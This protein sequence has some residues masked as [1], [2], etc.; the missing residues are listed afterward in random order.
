MCTKLPTIVSKTNPQMNV[1]EKW[2]LAYMKHITLD[3]NCWKLKE[4]AWNRDNI[5]M[6]CRQVSW[7]T[8]VQNRNMGLTTF[9][10][11]L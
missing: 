8:N 2:R 4:I 11:L 5:V 9:S 3:V 7:G 10:D 1:K 6:E